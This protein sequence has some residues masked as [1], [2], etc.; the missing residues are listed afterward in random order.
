MVGLRAGHFL[1]FAGHKRQLAA[2]PSEQPGA[3][4]VDRDRP[5]NEAWSEAVARSTICSNTDLVPHSI[6]KDHAAPAE[7]YRVALKPDS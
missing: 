1:L 2:K 7:I 3:Q 4:V 5:M 6:T